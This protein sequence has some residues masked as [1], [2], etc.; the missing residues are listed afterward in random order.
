MLVPS[1]RLDICE[2][3]PLSVYGRETGGGCAL[4]EGGTAEKAGT[5]TALEELVF[6]FEELEAAYYSGV[7]AAE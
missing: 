1:S 5:P 4:G 3:E 7:W 2:T 6:V